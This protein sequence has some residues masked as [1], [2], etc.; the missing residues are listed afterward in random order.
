[1][2]EVSKKAHY[3]HYHITLNAEFW[4]NIE[5]WLTY[6]PASNRVSYLTM[7]TGPAAQMW[8]CLPMPV[9][10]ALV[11]TFRANGVKVPFP[12]KPWM[13]SRWASTGMNF[14]LLPWLWL[15]G[16][17]NSK[18]N[19]CSFIVIMHQSY[20]SWLKLLPIARPWWPW[21]RH[22]LSFLCSIMSKC[23]VSTSQESTMK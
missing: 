8:S 21:S 13:T 2:I 17:L 5:W 3:L 22:S 15:C 6:L 23:T 1:M 12:S 18:A 9:I 7:Q 10:R 16:D 19:A 14:M 11:V 20:I 4:A